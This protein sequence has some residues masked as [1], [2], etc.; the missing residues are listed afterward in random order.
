MATEKTASFAIAIDAEAPNAR[1]AAS[2]LEALRAKI[3]ASQEAVKNYGASMRSLRGASDEVKDARTA[4][5]AKIE[6]ERD[7]VS[8]ANLV[9][10]KQGVTYEH[11]AKQQRAAQLAA[12][13]QA[14]QEKLTAAAVSKIGGPVVELREKLDSLKGVFAG[15]TTAQG[16]FAVGATAAVA[17][18]AALVTGVVALTAALVGGTIAFGKFVLEGANLARTMGLMREAA[19]GGVA[20]ASALGHQVDALAGKLATPKA[21]LNELALTMTRSMLFTRVSGQGLVDTFNAVGQASEAMGKTAGSKIQEIIE[22]GKT[23]GRMGLGRFE[24]QGTGITFEDVAGNLSKQLKIGL[25]DARFQLLAGWTD[26]NQGAKA[27]RTAI[28]K[29]FASINLRKMLDWDV[30]K[31]KFHENITALT[32]DLV[33]KLE[34]FL[35]KMMEVGKLFTDDT[36]AGAALKDIVNDLGGDML[37]AATGGASALKYGIKQLIIWALEL[38]IAVLKLKLAWR[39]FV[40]P[41]VRDRILSLNTALTLVKGTLDAMVK[42]VDLLTGASFGDIGKDLGKVVE[43][44]AKSGALTSDNMKA[45]EALVKG[46]GWGAAIMEG[47]KSGASSLSGEVTREFS[48][49]ADRVKSSFAGPL[50]IHSPSTEFH[51]YGQHTVEGYARGVESKQSDAQRSV[52]DMAPGAPSGGGGGMAR[53]GPV[54]VNVTINAGGGGNA[55]ET[56][57]AVTAPDVLLELTRAIEEALLGAGIP[58]QTTPGS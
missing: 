51:K 50:G 12:K 8:R 7:A 14:D 38:D 39:T 30:I 20:N 58:I 17:A 23:W 40:P 53:G 45:T 22:R 56:A 18:V 44:A 54:T 1:Q 27:I 43:S 21:E 37:K 49:I 47:I 35:K 13:K 5:K 15:M 46:Q 16:M 29:N 41:E 25:D 42:L 57:K 48:D 32:A 9:L 10:L 33:P 11:L 6:A 34:P 36:V 3:E 4:L 24:L 55:Q 2:E 19:G 26:V 31:L 52:N 28:E